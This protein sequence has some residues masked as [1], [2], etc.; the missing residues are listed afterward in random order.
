[1]L[2]QK[3]FYCKRELW[4]VERRKQKLKQFIYSVVIEFNWLPLEQNQI[5]H[6]LTTQPISNCSKTKTKTKVI[7]WLV[8]TLKGKPLYHKIDFI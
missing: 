7:I 8:S 1:M 2:Q 4:E 5:N 3:L 6:L